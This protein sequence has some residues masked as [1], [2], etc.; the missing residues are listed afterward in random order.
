MTN[1]RLVELARVAAGLT[2]GALAKELGKSQP[3]ISQ[4]E[5]GERDI[6]GDL[7]ST[8]SHACGLPISFFSRTEG[9]LSDPVAGMVHRR[10]KTLPTKPF[11]FANARVRLV[12]LEVDSLFAEVDI[13]PALDIP[14]LPK[15]TGPADAADSIRRAWRIPPGPL[16]NL[17]QLIESAGLPVIL[18]DS[19]HEKHSAASHRGRWF[20]WLIALNAQHPASRRRHTLAHEFGHI[21][22]GHDTG[23][24]VDEVDAQRMEREANA[25]AAELLFPSDEARRELRT[26]DFRRLV[27][28]K[29]RRQVSIA[30]LIRRAGD[31][32]LIDARQSQHLWIQLSSQPGGRRREPAE[33]EPEE[34][35]LIRRIIESLQ[36]DGLSVADI[37]EIMTITE[38][39]LRR[40]YLGERPHLRRVEDKPA[41]ATLHLQRP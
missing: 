13:V 9:P 39:D 41:R 25:F 14:E 19:F 18:L 26:L 27:A 10:M 1:P 36:N 32:E 34:P 23:V 38:S 24:V 2:Q 30:F 4:V 5:R 31:C 11:E 8:W 21:V 6:P 40:D 33:F 12:G 35:T 15:G 17:V 7:L 16:P 20:E 22:L 3:F 28:L 37:A 29:E